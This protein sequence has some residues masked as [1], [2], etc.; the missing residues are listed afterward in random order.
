MHTPKNFISFLIIA[1]TAMSFGSL[2]FYSEQEEVVTITS[3]YRI[4]EIADRRV[5]TEEQVVS[6][7]KYDDTGATDLHL[8]LSGTYGSVVLVPEMKNTNPVFIIPSSFTKHAGTVIYHLIQKGETIQEGAFKL[9]PD[10]ENLGPIETY[11]GPRSIVAN[12]RDYTMLV[13][14]PTD[15]LDNML[16]DSTQINL[17]SQFKNTITTTTHNLSSGMAWKRIFSPLQIGRVS[18]GST[19]GN[20]SSKE[21]IAD[22][23]PDTAQDFTITAAPNHT[24]AD[25]NEI[26]TFSTS[27]IRDAHNNVMTDGTL[28]TFFVQNSSGAYWQT[29]AST[30]NGYAFAKALH[31]QTPSTWQITAAINGIAQSP[32]IRQKF[33]AII[34]TIPVTISE[35]RTVKVGPLTSYLGQLVQN[36]ISVSIEIND[37][38]RE[39][40][41]ENGIVKFYVKEEEFPNGVYTLKVNTLGLEAIKKI[42]L[43]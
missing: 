22:V 40:L 34:E 16:P 27:Q 43:N 18:T 17:K 36:G 3:S 28:V 12:V 35:N 5:S 37:T 13:S 7:L 30:V 29:N 11:L 4:E 8:L 2:S 6:F 19:L 23:F 21:L 10:T 9:L 14:I 1:I 26:I 42:T 41:T 20:R 31:P 38:T 24:Y 39:G 15:T 25:G 33:T 32:E